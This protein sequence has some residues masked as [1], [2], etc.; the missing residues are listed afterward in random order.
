[1]LPFPKI[2]AGQTCTDTPLECS[3]GRGAVSCDILSQAII[4]FVDGWKWRWEFVESF[5]LLWK[6]DNC[7]RMLRDT[8]CNCIWH[9]SFWQQTHACC[10]WVLTDM[11]LCP[12][13]HK[14]YHTWQSFT[15][16]INT[17]GSS[18]V[19]FVILREIQIGR[20]LKTGR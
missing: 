17:Y 9:S 2:P 3:G 12:I 6:E 16:T 7:Y 15:T 8:N 20:H 11:T 1:M 13:I 19:Q 18:V 5:L 10:R 14:E 4:F